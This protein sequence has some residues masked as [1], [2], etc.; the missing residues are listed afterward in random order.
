MTFLSAVWMQADNHLGWMGGGW[1]PGCWLTRFEAEQQASQQHCTIRRCSVMALQLQVHY[2]Y[3]F[4]KLK[5]WEISSRSRS[6]CTALRLPQNLLRRLRHTHRH[7]RHTRTF[8]G[9]FATYVWND[10]GHSAAV[11]LSCSVAGR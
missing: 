9:H 2:G 6:H 3:V 11:R 8:T 4:V 7:V 1:L 5:V 10:R